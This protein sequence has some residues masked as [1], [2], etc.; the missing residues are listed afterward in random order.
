MIAAEVA[1]ALSELGPYGLRRISA[2]RITEHSLTVYRRER[3]IMKLNTKKG[4]Y[5]YVKEK[6]AE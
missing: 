3:T 6:E 1:T 4:L 5:M 2:F